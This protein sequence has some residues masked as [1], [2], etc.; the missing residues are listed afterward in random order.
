VELITMGDQYLI[1]KYGMYYR[2]N[3]QGYTSSRAEAGRY[4]LADAIRHSHPNG[5]DGPRDG[6]TYELAPPALPAPE[7]SDEL[8]ALRERDRR[9]MTDPQRLI[10]RDDVEG[11]C[12]TP[13]MCFEYGE[14]A[15]CGPCAIK[16]ATAC[17]VA[18]DLSLPNLPE[19]SWQ[20]REI[21][22]LNERV[23]ALTE[24]VE[25][26]KRH[27]ENIGITSGSYY[28]TLVAILSQPQQG[29]ER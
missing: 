28:E 6:I 26:A 23:A 10:W 21:A 17:G 16:Q 15:R 8:A 12:P 11:I 20:R 5:P 27:A 3:A 4:S 13:D 2:P 18:S 1:C 9:T 19:V 25:R 24:V 22:A 29:P 7:A 14:H